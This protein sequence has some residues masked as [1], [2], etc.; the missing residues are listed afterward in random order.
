MKK[1]FTDLALLILRLGFGGFMLT[2]GIPK[3]NK[4]SNAAEFPDPLGIG[5]LPSLILCLIGEVVAPILIIIGF[6]TKLAAIPA[7]ITMLVAAFV[8]HAKDDLGTKEHALLFCIAFVVIFLAGPG[9]LSID[10]S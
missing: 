5:G 2:H 3:L 4:L 7:A 10:K 1:N 8:V 9:K 6:K